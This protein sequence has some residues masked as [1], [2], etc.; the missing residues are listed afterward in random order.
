MK[1]ATAGLSDQI[2]DAASDL[3]SV[4]QGQAKRGLS[5]CPGQHGLH[6]GRRIRPAWSR[7][8]GG[9][10]A[11]L[12]A[13]RHSR[14]HGPGTTPIRRRPRSRSR[15]PDRRDLAAVALEQRIATRLQNTPRPAPGAGRNRARRL[16]LDV[17]KQGE[18]KDD[19][20]DRPKSSGRI[21]TPTGAVRPSW[22]CADDQNDK[23]D[24]NDKTHPPPPRPFAPRASQQR[25]IRPSVPWATAL[26]AIAG[27]EHRDASICRY[28]SDFIPRA[29]AR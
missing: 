5:T 3:R 6:R 22:K 17:S 1:S 23:N 29:R 9:A 14:G 16:L 28:S 26:L 19:N 15:I 2:A 24:E 7:R 18:D 4:A 8:W 21:V 10:I 27:V 11:S 12:L 25:Q 13:R 20:Q